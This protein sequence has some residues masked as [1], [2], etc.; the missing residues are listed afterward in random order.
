[1]KGKLWCPERRIWSLGTSENREEWLAARK[2]KL[3]ASDLAS[4]AGVGMRRRSEVLKEKLDAADTGADDK[5]HAMPQVEAGRY[6]ESGIINWFADQ[7]LGKTEPF[8]ELLYREGSAEFLAATPDALYEGDPLEVKNIDGDAQWNW[9]VN[10]TPRDGWPSYLPFPLPYDAHG[11]W[12]MR[13]NKIAKKWQG[14]PVGAWREWSVQRSTELLPLL[15]APCAP[16]KYVV[17]CY[18]Q[19]YVLKRTEFVITAC[20]GGVSRL[21]LFYTVHGQTLTW[22]LEQARV[23]WDEVQR[24]KS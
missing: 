22:L 20:I 23:F 10:T 1:M 12:A 8:G 16:V 13:T 5:L 7:H 17:Q 18:A 15:G 11:N 21:D 6:L 14:T 24:S 3:T 2:T 9:G 19:A 4:V